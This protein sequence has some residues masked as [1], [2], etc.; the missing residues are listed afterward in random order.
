MYIGSRIQKLREEKGLSQKEASCGIISTSHYSNVES[1]R[2]VPSEDVLRLLA[3]RFDVPV[4]YFLDTQKP[5]PALQKLLDEYEQLLSLEVEQI[6]RFTTKHAAKF[7]YIPSILQE[8]TYN[9]LKY[10]DLV[11]TGQ[12]RQAQKL[13]AKEM[14]HLSQK[15][16]ETNKPLF[17]NY[18]YISGLFC[19]FNKNYRAS[20]VYFRAILELARS[21]ET[22][23]KT[24]YNMSLAFFHLFDYAEALDYVK[25]AQ[26]QYMNL[27]K[28]IA[29]GDCYNLAATILMEQNKA[30]EA[31]RQ[32]QKGFSVLGD[33]VSETSARLYHN[34]AY[35]QF[36]EKTYYDALK[37]INQ[38]IELK[39]KMG[40]ENLIISYTLKISILFH[41]EDF[42]AIQDNLKQIQQFTLQ[43]RES[44]QLRYI[45]TKMYYTVRE[46]PLYEKNMQGCIQYFQSN[47][48]WK[49]LK[50]AARH[51]SIY[52]ANQKK[53]KMAHHYQDL[54]I[55]SYQRLTM[56]VKGGEME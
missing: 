1:G 25:R 20:I 29:A 47:E 21:E 45:E 24:F 3:E 9:V 40:S 2:F 31:M 55:L 5:N 32:I 50:E 39:Q 13:Y 38:C 41:L 7:S 30:T 19:Y 23:A 34:L 18:L 33:S 28:W 8:F 14:I 15:D 48:E 11:K 51:F 16:L 46:F 53:Y 49:Y 26:Q 43:E 56:E 27:H 54:C 12:V 10:I 44:I 6:R 42:M 4:P 22:I 37:T 35:I 52:Y 17:I 36:K